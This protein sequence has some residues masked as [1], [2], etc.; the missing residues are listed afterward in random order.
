MISTISAK[1]APNNSASPCNE[2]VGTGH[3]GIGV[4]VARVPTA[5][6]LQPNSRPMD[7]IRWTG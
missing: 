3:V 6:G 2:N 4:P 5:T 7:V 1:Q